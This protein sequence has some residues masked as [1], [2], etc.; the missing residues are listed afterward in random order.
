M[1]TV[2]HALLE[3]L[4]TVLRVLIQLK[5]RL[6]TRRKVRVLFVLERPTNPTSRPA[7]P[8]ILPAR[9]V[10][11]EPARIVPLVPTADT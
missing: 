5:F 1:G 3:L 8:V 2:Q 11:E 6:I 9:L 10:L 7:L 4:V